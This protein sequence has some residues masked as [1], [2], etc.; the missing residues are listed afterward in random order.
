MHPIA[1]TPRLLMAISSTVE[2]TRDCCGAGWRAVVI[3]ADP[4]ADSNHDACALSGLQA[5]QG[6]A[7]REVCLIPVSAH[8]TNPASAAMC[9]MRI[10]AIGCDDQGNIDMADLKAKAEKHAD[11]LSALMVTYP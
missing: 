2:G 4:A 3:A 9:G 10:V 8:G 5:A 6:E 11:K 1:T 7:H